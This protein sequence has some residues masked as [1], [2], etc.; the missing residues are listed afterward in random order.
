M[1][2]G[3]G[4]RKPS[5]TATVAAD[6]TAAIAGS[7]LRRVDSRPLPNLQGH[8][9]AIPSDTFRSPLLVPPGL[10]PKMAPIAWSRDLRLK[11]S[12]VACENSRD[13]LNI[14]MLTF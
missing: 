13:L 3:P 8:E 12:K 2:T 5:A 10:A 14:I 4:F 7:S 1:P 6:S 9:V 11:F